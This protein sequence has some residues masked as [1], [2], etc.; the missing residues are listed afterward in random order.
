MSKRPS[1]LYIFSNVTLSMYFLAEV[2]Q[3]DLLYDNLQNIHLCRS[4]MYIACYPYK[5]VS[6]F[7]RQ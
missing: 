4:N 3:N 5:N 7:R 1:A 6:M 2:M